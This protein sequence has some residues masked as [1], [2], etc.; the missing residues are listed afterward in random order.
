MS[1]LKQLTTDDF[2]GTT[3]F[4]ECVSILHA[5]IPL[6]GMEQDLH[7]T[8]KVTFLFERSTELDHVVRD[9]WNDTLRV[10]PRQWHAASRDLK[11]R[12]RAQLNL[13]RR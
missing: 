1:D 12:I 2:Y 6:F 8:H 11:A 10:S 5:G 3:E 13:Q 4:A 9:F 7:S